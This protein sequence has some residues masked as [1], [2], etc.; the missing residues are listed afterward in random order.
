MVFGEVIDKGGEPYSAD[1]RGVLKTFA[2]GQF[3]KEWLHAQ[4]GQ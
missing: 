2:E 4:R 1:M 3:K